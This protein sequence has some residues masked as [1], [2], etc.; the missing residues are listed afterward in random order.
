V[1]NGENHSRPATKAT[2]FLLVE[3]TSDSSNKVK[4]TIDNFEKKL[5]EEKRP[6]REHIE[7]YLFLIRYYFILAFSGLNRMNSEEDPQIIL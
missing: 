5:M 4:S 7:R 2:I 3:A 1:L 6:K